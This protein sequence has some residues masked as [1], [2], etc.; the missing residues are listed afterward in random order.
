MFTSHLPTVDSPS[1]PHPLQSLLDSTEWPWG[2]KAL[3][4]KPSRPAYVPCSSVPK[5]RLLCPPDSKCASL[6][7]TNNT[8][9]FSSSLETGKNHLVIPC[10]SLRLLK[11]FHPS[12]SEKKSS[13]THKT[14]EGRCLKSAIKS[15]STLR[16]EQT[17]LKSSLLMKDNDTKATSSC[18]KKFQYPP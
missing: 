15:L 18:L 6:S 2:C 12:H 8:P 3:A 1:S 13:N 7:L 5:C 16:A 4:K 9:S 14:K 17:V 11:D 10:H